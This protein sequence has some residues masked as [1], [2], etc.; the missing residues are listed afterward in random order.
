MNDRKNSPKLDRRSF[1]LAS[2]AGAA[3]AAAV[4]VTGVTGLKPEPAEALAT[5]RDADGLTPHMKKYYQTTL[6]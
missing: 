5:T 4:V 3:G 1:L 6:I 2:G